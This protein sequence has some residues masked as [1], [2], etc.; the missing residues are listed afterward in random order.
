MVLGAWMW[1]AN[2]C[3]ETRIEEIV[4]YQTVLQVVYPDELEV[5]DM[6]TQSQT[7]Y[8][9][10]WLKP[11]FQPLAEAARGGEVGSGTRRRGCP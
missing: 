5:R 8:R 7:T 6:S 2:Y 3:V 1:H 11:Q 10:K 9:R 4:R